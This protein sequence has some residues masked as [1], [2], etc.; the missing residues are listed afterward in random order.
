MMSASHAS[1]RITAGERSRPSSVR[2]LDDPR[3]VQSIWSRSTSRLVVTEMRGRAPWESGATSVARA[4]SATVM[5]ASQR[6]AP[7]SRGSTP[8]SHVSGS[9]AG[10]GVVS[11]RSAALSV[12]ASSTVP[13]PRTR[14]PPAPSSVIARNRPRC[15]ARVSRSAAFSA[16]RSVCS[17]SATSRRCLAALASSVAF[18]RVAWSRR[19]SSPCSRRSIWWGSWSM[20]STITDACSGESIPDARAAWVRGS[21]PTSTGACRT[22]RWPGPRWVPAR[23]VN[24]SDVEPQDRWVLATLRASTST[25]TEASRAASWA[26]SASSSSTV[27]TSSPGVFAAH[28]T[29]PRPASSTRAPATTPAGVRGVVEGSSTHRLNQGAPTVR[30]L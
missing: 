10:A 12:A 24:Q 25:S 17:G 5:R 11:G 14:T 16:S 18:N 20:A 15:A 27:P 21:S 13:R 7:W 6:R 4:W 28:S 30:P 19:N 22:A 8:S 29:S 23:W 1:R 2:L 9:M 3:V 26:R